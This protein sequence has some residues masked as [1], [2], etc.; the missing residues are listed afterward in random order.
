MINLIGLAVIVTILTEIDSFE[1][2]WLLDGKAFGNR[3]FKLKVS[4]KASQGIVPHE[5]LIRLCSC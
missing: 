1:F 5:F 3:S 2:L 4:I